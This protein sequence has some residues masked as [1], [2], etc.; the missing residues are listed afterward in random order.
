MNTFRE[1]KSVVCK[2]SSTGGVIEL[3]MAEEAP[4]ATA[5]PEEMTVGGGGVEGTVAGNCRM[6]SVYS[7]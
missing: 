2:L 4:R 6:E 1:V 7:R 3:L 5:E